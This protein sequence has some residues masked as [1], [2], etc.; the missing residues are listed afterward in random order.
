VGA[1]LF[2][3]R[4][5]RTDKSGATWTHLALLFP[6]LIPLFPFFSLEMRNSYLLVCHS[7]PASF[8]KPIVSAFNRVSATAAITGPEPFAFFYYPCLLLPRRSWEWFPVPGLLN[9]FL[10]RRVLPFLLHLPLKSLLISQ[11]GRTS[12]FFFVKFSQFRLCLLLT[13][14]DYQPFSNFRPP[15]CSPLMFSWT[16]R[17]HKASPSC[18]LCR[19]LCPNVLPH[20]SGGSYPFRANCLF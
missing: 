20:L 15:L 18:G 3:I 11:R 8:S 9:K 5:S 4:R 16:I 17:S 14:Q 6:P 7:L 2:R 13:A 12:S 19:G 1:L 10:R